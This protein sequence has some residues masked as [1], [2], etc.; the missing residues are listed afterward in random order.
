MQT[1]GSGRSRV[2]RLGVAKCRWKFLHE[3]HS[4]W[5][6]VVRSK[7][8]MPR[9]HEIG[10]RARPTRSSAWWRDILSMFFEGESNWF[11]ISVTRKIGAGNLTL[12]WMDP[13][14]NGVMLASKYQRLFNLS[15]QQ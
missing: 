5:C 14:L 7:Y 2:K 9:E 3:Q 13:W 1:K 12:F 6:R 11:D 4:L 15:N 8:N 10:L